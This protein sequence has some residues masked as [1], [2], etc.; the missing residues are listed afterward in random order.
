[1]AQLPPSV[2]ASLAPPPSPSVTSLLRS[3]AL[4]R[5][6]SRPSWVLGCCA[7]VLLCQSTVT[8][9]KMEARKRK[10]PRRAPR[11]APLLKARR[12]ETKAAAATKHSSG[13]GGAK[14]ARPRKH[15]A[16]EVDEAE[17][18][19]D[20]KMTVDGEEDEEESGDE[21]E[22]EE[23]SGDE[24]EE[25]EEEEEDSEE[26]EDEEDPDRLY[27]ICQ[28]PYEA[29]KPMVQCDMCDDWYAPQ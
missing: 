27:C 21:E 4:S 25:S 10:A 11:K 29:G 26:D 15:A 22:E 9:A 20:A 5:P 19:H 3:L 14:A 23:E 17:D 24:G 12:A 28:K 18:A 16:G 6:P 13:G 2:P 7:A 8:C 1:M